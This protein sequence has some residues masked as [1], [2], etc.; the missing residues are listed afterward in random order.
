MSDNPS[1]VKIPNN[2]IEFM[3][4][5]AIRDDLIMS[6]L[7]ENTEMLKRVEEKISIMA[8]DHLKAWV[9]DIVSYSNMIIKTTNEV[10][11]RVGD[12]DIAELMQELDTYTGAVKT[13]IKEVEPEHIEQLLTDAFGAGKNE[14]KDRVDRLIGELHTRFNHLEQGIIDIR[15]KNIAQI[16]ENVIEGFNKTIKGLNL[17]NKNI[18]LVADDIINRVGNVDQ[19]VSTVKSHVENMPKNPIY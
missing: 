18:L 6:K 2:M 5:M 13:L 8:K 19:K 14:D 4:Q 9:E 12:P 3:Q 7:D 10:E 16:G 17:T 11:E 15:D 1:V